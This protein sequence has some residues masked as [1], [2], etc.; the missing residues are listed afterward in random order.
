MAE[1]FNPF[2]D[3]PKI[4]AGSKKDVPVGGAQISCPA[5]GIMVKLPAT[6][7]PECKAN[8]RTGEK[9]EE[10]VP[11]WK[12]KKGKLIALIMLF[13]LPS[14]SFSI[15]SSQTDDG[16]MEYLRQKLGLDSCAE[17]R[18]MWE[19]F[20]QR[21]FEQNVK[22]GYSKWN[23]LLNSRIL[24]QSA[25]GPETEDEAALSEREKMAEKDR[26]AYFADTLMDKGPSTQLQAK[27]NWFVTLPGEWDVAYI[28]APGTAEEQIIAG[29]WIFSWVNDGQALQDVLSVPYRWQKPPFGFRAIQSTGIRTFNAKHGFWEGFKILEGRLAYFRN[30]RTSTGQIM[31]Q[32]KIDG[33]PLTVAVFGDFQ[34]M[35]FQLTISESFDNGASYKVL[36]ELWAK[37]REIYINE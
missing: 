25:R 17:P 1:Y 23:K 7:C 33:G 6:E 2:T 11:L 30:I 34:V 32:H 18:D 20:S 19:E 37:K 12:R 4:S 35:S 13:L 14:V 36:A 21:E 31:E 3:P 28:S 29:E 26:R 16:V 5:C 15:L 8:L 10:Y 22:S 24:G 27:D 9:P